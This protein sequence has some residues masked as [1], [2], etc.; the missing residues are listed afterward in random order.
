MYTGINY[1]ISSILSVQ[2]IQENMGTPLLNEHTFDSMLPSLLEF[3][4]ILY[5]TIP[6]YLLFVHFTIQSMEFDS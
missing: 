3:H 4:Y 1:F 5:V 6:M 2:I